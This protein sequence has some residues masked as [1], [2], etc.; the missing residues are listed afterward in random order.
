MAVGDAEFQ[1][2]AI[3]KMQDITSGNARTVLFVSHNTGSI[4]TL[5]KRCLVIDK[6]KIIFDGKTSQKQ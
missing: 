3:G 2:K 5:T 4:S 1:K 6:G